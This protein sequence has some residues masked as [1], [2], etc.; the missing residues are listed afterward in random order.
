MRLD[1]AAV[2]RESLN[3]RQMAKRQWDR[4]RTDYRRE[5]LRCDGSAVLPLAYRRR[6]SRCWRARWILQSHA[7]Q[8]FESDRD[9]R[10]IFNPRCGVCQIFVAIG[11]VLIC[12]VEGVGSLLRLVIKFLVANSPV[13]KDYRPR[14]ASIHRKVNS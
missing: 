5:R 10:L 14:A 3:R 2:G 11:S 6:A 4:Y 8:V 13:A 1:A 7:G 9:A 12:I